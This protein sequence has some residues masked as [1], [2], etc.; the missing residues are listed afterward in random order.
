MRKMLVPLAIALILIASFA[1]G[2]WYVQQPDKPRYREVRVDR[3]SIFVSILAT[4]V[5]QPQNRVDIKPAVGGRVEDVLVREG[6]KVQ[7][8]QIL[9]WMSSTERAA[10]LDAARSLGKEELTKWEAFYRPTPIS[11]PLPGTIIQRRVEPGQTF[12]AGDVILV[13]SDRLIIKAQVDETDLARVKLRQAAE[14]VLDAYSD[15]VLPAKVD[16][17]AF[18]AK[19]VN[20]VTTYTVDV[21][22]DK[23][24]EHMRA[25]M[26]ANVTFIVERRDGT[27]M[28]PSE[29]LRKKEGKP[30]VLVRGPEGTVSESPVETGITDGKNIEIVSGL[31]E[32][33]TILTEIFTLKQKSGIG[34]NPFAEK[35]RSRPP[36]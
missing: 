5:V 21:L 32:G 14:I 23:T 4:G 20:N 16:Q 8:D 33:Q 1:A 7:R 36:R 25:G 18:E 3:G 2:V 15:D 30:V 24:P 6:H 11:A 27:L 17:I 28:I 13:M 12:A 34:A 35:P 26:T 29:A 22:P 9:V 31:T 19:T 10:L